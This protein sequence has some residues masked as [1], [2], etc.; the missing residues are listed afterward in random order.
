MLKQEHLVYGLFTTGTLITLQQPDERTVFSLLVGTIIGSILPDILDRPTSSKHRKLFHDPCFWLPVCCGL[1]LYSSLCFG[2]ILG[3]FLHLLLDSTTA[4]G[5]P[6]LY[7]WKRKR[8]Y[9]HLFPKCIKIY[10][11]SKMATFITVCFCLLTSFGLVQIEKF[12]PAVLQIF[13][14]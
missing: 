2:F 8:K 13:V 1:F 9:F 12:A 3:I 4:A 5:I 11:N 14:K 7:L 6:I 10:A